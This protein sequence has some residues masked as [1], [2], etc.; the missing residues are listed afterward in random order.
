MSQIDAT[1]QFLNFLHLLRPQDQQHHYP[2]ARPQV[3]KVSRPC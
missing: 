1:Q 2:K 3:P